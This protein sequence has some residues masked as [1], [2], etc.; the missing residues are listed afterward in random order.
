MHP[1]LSSD[2]CV[3]I[4]LL[5]S[6]EDKYAMEIIKQAHGF[7]NAKKS[8]DSND[9]NI[10]KLIESLRGISPEIVLYSTLIEKMKTENLIDAMK[11]S[12]EYKSIFINGYY[13]KY[14]REI[15]QSPWPLAHGGSIS[16]IRNHI[17]YPG[18]AH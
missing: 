5:H 12:T 2:F 4:S 9:M 11:I 3:Y 18:R 6:E 13:N 1:N 17:I 7:V 14:S 10:G 8:H 15:S 16:L